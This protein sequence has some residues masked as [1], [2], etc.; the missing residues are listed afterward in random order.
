MA[1]RQQFDLIDSGYYSPQPFPK[2]RSA[3]VVPSVPSKQSA[4]TAEFKTG[5][6]STT[7][8]DSQLAEMRSF[9]M[10]EFASLRQAAGT[11]VPPVSKPSVRAPSNNHSGMHSLS[12]LQL[13]SLNRAHLGVHL[14][15]PND[16]NISLQSSSDDADNGNVNNGAEANGLDNDD[17][18]NGLDSA[19]EDDAS[20]SSSLRSSSS[21]R[22]QPKV[23][24]GIPGVP[25]INSSSGGQLA[26]LSWIA[27]HFERA[28]LNFPA[29]GLGASSGSIYR[30]GKAFG[31]ARL[32]SVD[33]GLF[34]TIDGSVSLIYDA[35]SLEQ[36]Q[37]FT[38]EV[39][40]V[41]GPTK[42]FRNPC[43]VPQHLLLKS[44]WPAFP[45]HYETWKVDITANL[46]RLTLK[47]A[48]LQG[49]LKV[50]E[51]LT[52]FLDGIIYREFPHSMLHPTPFTKS[53]PFWVTKWVVILQFIWYTHTRAK[54]H[55][56][57]YL[58]CADLSNYWIHGGFA[59]KLNQAGGTQAGLGN[60]VTGTTMK[61]AMVY[62]G[63]R[64]PNT[65]CTS[66]HGM[67]EK[68]CFSCQ[69]GL[70][71]AAGNQPP[72]A[73]SNN[74]NQAAISKA[75]TAYQASPAGVSALTISKAECDRLF[76]IK[77]ANLFTK[78]PA[79]VLALPSLAHPLVHTLDQAWALFAKH[80]EVIV[81]PG[82]PR[83][84]AAD[85]AYNRAGAG[86]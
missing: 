45:S 37:K 4:T 16:D 5:P 17:E 61:D 33:W 44:A 21:S 32:D 39:V 63:F 82:P 27:T 79:V 46:H 35:R 58:L 52:S 3:P 65:T 77:Y 30:E 28:K 64:C 36:K 31:L 14:D 26:R 51:Q 40:L 13:R 2:T 25:P 7:D 55:C 47:P 6:S 69:R 1:L 86:N 29:T 23:R 78:Q 43:S 80:Q 50:M 10:A 20:I 19:E 83:D 59:E 74:A 41:W 15:P 9:M 72:K 68:D 76:R 18:A 42:E 49:R 48:V 75:R 38:R 24:S 67:T 8:L 81:A 22:N 56:N 54:A 66:P 12:S 71:S 57:W 34:P 70:F 73:S 11:A 84:S 62:A 85:K 60:V 53:S